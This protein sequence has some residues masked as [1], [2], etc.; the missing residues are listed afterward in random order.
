MNT[1]VICC[2]VVLLIIFKSVFSQDQYALL[3]GIKGYIHYE[4]EYK[5]RYSDKDA[6]KVAELLGSN[7]PGASVPAANI[8]LVL[9]DTATRENILEAVK[10]IGKCATVNDIVYIYFSG[11]GES[12]N[13]LSYLMP[14][15][16][17]LSM[18]NPIVP[19]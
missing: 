14:R 13:G 17:C 12:V 10:W 5:L 8:K 4:K 19:I 15:T 3:I 6:I 2:V 7:S 9:N 16:L 1:K 11:H 18:L